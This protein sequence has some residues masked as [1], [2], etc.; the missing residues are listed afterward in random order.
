MIYVL[1]F[2]AGFLIGAFVNYVMDVIGM[3]KLIREG[4]LF[5]KNADGTWQ[6][7]DPTKGK[8]SG[9]HEKVK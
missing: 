9:F 6:P 5:R 4:K 3:A 8:I 2:V 7:Y 1:V